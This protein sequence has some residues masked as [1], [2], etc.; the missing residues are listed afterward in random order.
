MKQAINLKKTNFM[1]K[2]MYSSIESSFT[3]QACRCHRL[4][5]F[6]DFRHKPSQEFHLQT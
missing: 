4:N 5:F 6:E 1:V 3:Y 2:L